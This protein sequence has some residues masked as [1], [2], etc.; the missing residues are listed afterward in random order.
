M[1][2]DGAWR[3]LPDEALLAMVDSLEDQITLVD[4]A[5]NIVFVNDSWLCFADDNGGERAAVGIGRNYFDACARAAEAGDRLAAQVLDGMRSLIAG[6]TADFTFEYPCHAPDG[7]RWFV[8]RMRPVRGH[9]GSLF[10]IS[11]VDVTRRKLAELRVERLA[12][13]DVLT[14]LANRR[15]FDQALR[16]E[17]RRRERAA[18]PLSVIA[19]DIDH[20]KSY[21][22]AFGH[23]EGDRCLQAVGGSLRPCARRASDVAARLGGEE[24]WLLLCDT[25][26]EQAARVAEQVRRTVAQLGARDGVCRKVTASLGVATAAPDWEGTP[27]TLM[28]LADAALYAAKRAGRDCVR[29]SAGERDNASAG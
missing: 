26:A 12:Y 15:R 22:D 1:D 9:V 20:F 24:F 23:F 11:H 2:K 3:K 29:R 27:E 25:T 8:I 7:E 4:E 17:W 18:L 16:T 21:N 5:G 14:G 6:R 13:E 19:L 10:V 28:R